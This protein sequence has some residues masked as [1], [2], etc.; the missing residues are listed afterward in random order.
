M[1][2]TKFIISSWFTQNAKMINFSYTCISQGGV[3]T[4]LKCGGIFNNNN[5]DDVCHFR[6]TVYVYKQFFR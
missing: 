3:V 4:Q 6:H 1:M 5:L 2:T